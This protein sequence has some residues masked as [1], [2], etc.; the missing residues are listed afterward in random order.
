MAKSM[1]RNISKDRI[2]LRWENK[3]HFVFFFINLFC[4]LVL[5]ALGVH[6]CIWAF[7]AYG[8]QASHFSNPKGNQPWIVIRRTDAEA[9]APILWPHDE[10]NWLIRKDPD[11]GEDWRQEKGT[12]EDEMVEWHHWLNEHEF[13][14]AS[15]DGEWLG[16]LACCSLR[17]NKELDMTKWLNNTLKAEG[18]VT[19]TAAQKIKR[20]LKLQEIIGMDSIYGPTNL[21]V[22]NN[23]WGEYC[24]V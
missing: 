12:T 13:E 1:G 10:K 21:H 18:V 5:A 23:I 4:Y 8:I 14:Q 15:G 19:D 11:I 3:F 16:I 7:S 24:C 20:G 17:C 22:S 9:K 2:Y 6:C